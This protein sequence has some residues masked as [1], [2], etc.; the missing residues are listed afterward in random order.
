M[1]PNDKATAEAYY[2]GGMRAF[3]S[4]DVKNALALFLSAARLGHADAQFRVGVFFYHG[5]VVKKDDIEALKWFRKAA[6]QGHLAAMSELGI[7]YA[8]GK[9]T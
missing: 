7:M 1:A 5:I 4:K 8:E 3:E 6:L 9:K 2:E